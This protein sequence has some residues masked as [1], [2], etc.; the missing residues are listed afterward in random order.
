M[1]DIWSL[2]GL[3]PATDKSIKNKVRN[4]T[5]TFDRVKFR[6]FKPSN[7]PTSAL[8]SYINNDLI[9]SFDFVLISNH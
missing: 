1:L 7:D 6:E 8:I 2:Y 9:Y 3:I 5:V 4:K